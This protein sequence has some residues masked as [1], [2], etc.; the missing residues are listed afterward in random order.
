MFPNEENLDT[1]SSRHIYAA[2][3]WTL[4]PLHL[5]L[6]R[7]SGKKLVLRF[8]SQIAQRR[9]LDPKYSCASVCS[10]VEMN[11]VPRAEILTTNTRAGGSLQPAGKIWREVH[12]LRE[13]WQILLTWSLTTP[14]SKCWETK[15]SR[16]V[17]RG[18]DFLF[19]SILCLVLSSMQS[20]L[21]L[22]YKR[23][24]GFYN[25]QRF[26]ILSTIKMGISISSNS[27][28]LEAP[29]EARQCPWWTAFFTDLCSKVTHPYEEQGGLSLRPVAENK[30]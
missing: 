12:L 16:L 19:K 11:L 28:I 6:R 2:H 23:G 20:T 13:A 7:W 25:F 30:Q 18:K 24:S 8:G 5:D 9:S 17:I 29:E 4:V 21:D 27:V 15:P 1:A 3:C 10:V 22:R 14:P 26:L